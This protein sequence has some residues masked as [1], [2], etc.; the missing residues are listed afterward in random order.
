MKVCIREIESTFLNSCQIMEEIMN[1]LGGKKKG[2]KRELMTTTST[3]KY[4]QQGRL[5]R[6]LHFYVK[7]S[8][9]IQDSEKVCGVNISGSRRWKN[10]TRKKESCRIKQKY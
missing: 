9:T 7:P 5:K 4:L 8:K 3:E 6:Q 1:S 2:H 10:R